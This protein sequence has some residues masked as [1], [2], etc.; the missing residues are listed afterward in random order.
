MSLKTIYSGLV[1][2]YH[3][4]SRLCPVSVPLNRVSTG[5]E[6]HCAPTACRV[7]SAFVPCVPL[8]TASLVRTGA[9]AQARNAHMRKGNYRVTTGQT[10]QRDRNDV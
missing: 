1:E 3:Y 7:L 6:T 4:L 10:G 5:H 8:K 2:F 9:C